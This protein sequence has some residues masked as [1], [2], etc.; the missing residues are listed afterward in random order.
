MRWLVRELNGME[1]QDFI[2]LC[3]LSRVQTLGK[4]FYRGIVGQVTAKVICLYA[5][6]TFNTLREYM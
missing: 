5:H 6:I 1:V 2:A 3:D 4:D